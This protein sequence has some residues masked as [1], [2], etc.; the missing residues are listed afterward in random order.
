M[1]KSDYYGLILAGGRGTRFWPRSRR[2]RAKQV[3]EL[4]G[5]GTLIQQTVGRLKPIIPPER[6]WV[7]TNDY[8]RAEIAKQLPGVPKGQILAE[9][10]ARNTA[11]AIGL[12][13]H[14]LQSI[15]PKA[16]LGVFPADHYITRP[17]RFLQ[18][19]RPAFRA[20]GSG[21]LIVIGIQPHRPET[22]YGYIE[23]A[24]GVEAGRPRAVPVLSFREK[25]DLA[26]AKQF[27]EAGNYFWNSGMFFGRVSTFLGALREHMPKTATVLAGLPE[28]RSR[29]FA[30]SMR[31][32]FPLC[33]NLSIDYGVIEK[34]SN[35]AGLAS[36]DIGWN[37]VGSWEAVAELQQTDKNGNAARGE[38][39]F[40]DASRNYV[41][42][43]GKLVVLL[44]VN[45]LIVVDTPDALL[46][47]GR[48][49]SQ[50][51]GKLV[52]RLEQRKRDDLL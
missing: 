6:I 16:I 1:S 45:G 23:F 13:A 14:I 25:P 3:L 24:P 2:R 39:L 48:K 32:A 41:D 11:P 43:S 46:V 15:N 4:F 8:L 38:A 26:T 19:L 22:G 37:D 17:A 20:A 12:A 51:V 5:S 21:S 36:G 31:E 33:E 9:P 28:F 29:R 10:A 49:R 34:A 47:A 40:Q 35:V 42:S 30:G 7:L 50:Q 27:I 52:A 18:L 44:G